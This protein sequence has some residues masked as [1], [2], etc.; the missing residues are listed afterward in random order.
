MSLGHRSHTSRC[1]RSPPGCLRGVAGPASKRNGF[2]QNPIPDSGTKPTSDGDVDF[3]TEEGFQ[4]DNKCSVIEEAPPGLE[5]HEQIYVAIRRSLT[6]RH[7]SEN[8]HVARPVGFRRA[9]NR[10]PVLAEELFDS[11]GRLKGI[12]VAKPLR[13][14]DDA[15]LEG[16]D[17]TRV[18]LTHPTSASR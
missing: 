7:R 5:T 18:G 8:A 16:L 2:L 9:E 15:C 17:E 14:I 1:A 11:H 12:V 3:A 13:V 6:P 10:R 4:L